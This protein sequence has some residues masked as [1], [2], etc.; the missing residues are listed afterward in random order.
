MNNMRDKSDKMREICI[1]QGYT[2]PKC[3]LPGMI[4]MGLIKKG[5]CPCDGCNM[6]RTDCDG[7]PKKY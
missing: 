7:K 5:E 6:D 2:L 1:E 3:K 4:I